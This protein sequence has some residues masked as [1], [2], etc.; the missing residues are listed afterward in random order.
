MPPGRL[1]SREGKMKKLIVVGVILLFLGSSIPALA[2]SSSSKTIYVDDDNT[3]GPWD[4][5][6]EHP[7]QHIQD[8][9]DASIEKDTVFVFSG[10]YIENVVV[11]KSI[12]LIGENRESTIV[13]SNYNGAPFFLQVHG[14]TLNGFTVQ[15]SV[16]TYY[17]AGIIARRSSN[18]IIFDN[19]I[20][21]NYH[22]LSL[23]FTSRD[24]IYD[25]IIV[26]NDGY[27]IYG[28][29]DV[30]YSNISNNIFENNTIGILLD[31]S[32]KNNIINNVIS[33][34]TQYNI[35]MKE[36]VVDNSI[37]NNKIAYSK[38]GLSILSAHRNL[39]TN[40]DIMHNE[41]GVF[42][43]ISRMNKIMKNNFIDNIVHA[44]FRGANF[45]S[46]PTLWFANYWSN[47]SVR[48]VL[49]IKGT[50]SIIIDTYRNTFEFNFPGFEIAF[51]SVS[52]PYVFPG[53]FQ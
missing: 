31:K 40:N 9:I 19:I 34:N 41:V 28:Q 1:L 37:K 44:R 47:L 32:H 22:G 3:E 39:I 10:L 42:V 23:D 53:G 7:Y 24:C 14:I 49:L 27:G 33:N 30:S 51:C 25:N 5:T 2:N 52:K 20:K 26:N 16:P 13:D 46:S 29:Q 38:E 4:G 48:P 17:G 18:H 8:G 45:R 6:W 43:A 11:N 12:I 21:E 36:D 50:R 15:H 35:I